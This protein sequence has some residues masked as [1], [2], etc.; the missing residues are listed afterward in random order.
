MD[1]QLL[2]NQQKALTTDAQEIFFG[3]ALGGGK[4]FLLRH[5][6]V[7]Y[8]LYVP[9]ITT[10]LL[11]RTYKDLTKNHVQSQH[12]FAEILQPFIK[13]GK[14]EFNLTDMRIDFHHEN[15]PDSH[16]YLGH[17]Q[18]EKDVYNYQGMEISGLL[19]FDELTH[20]T[21]TIYTYLITRLRSGSNEIDYKEVRKYLPW[22]YD[23]YFPKI[24]SASNP[25]GIGA[26]FARKRWIDP[27]PPYEVWTA[28]ASEGGMKR[29]YIPSRLQD[30]KFLMEQDPFYGDRVLASGTANARK[31]L[32][33]DW[34]INEGGAVADV[35]DEEVHVIPR[36]HIPDNAIIY[37][38]LDWGTFHPSVVLYALKC[39]GETLYTVDGQELNFPNGTLVIFNEIYNWDGE[40]EN[41][42][43]RKPATEV[44]MQMAE[45]ESQVPWRQRIKPGPADRQIFQQR[46]GTH[47]TIDN[48]ISKGYNQ[49]MRNLAEKDSTF[50]WRYDIQRLFEQAD[51]QTG[52]RVT[53]LSLVR[54]FL[55]A[56]LQYHEEG[57]DRRSLFFTENARH[58]I[59]TIPGLPR[60][61]T[62]PEDVQTNHVPDHAYDVVRYLCLAQTGEYQPLHLKGI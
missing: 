33:G 8:G 5:A 25:G 15:G 53:G 1:L 20:F 19:L 40:D 35:W 14:C 12:G 29:I 2:P 21:K 34:S 62:N 46:G 61:E 31:L 38:A 47:D 52:S 55:M 42:G 23:G 13:A 59:A 41:N 43:N 60:S 44:G 11:R 36:I 6:A 26:A 16:I 24:I 10:V 3:G 57:A 30:N 39:N 49:Y 9:G 37:R 50:R 7:I 18:Y 4:S 28:P 51:Q 45:F 48:L 32:D 58:C 54:D 17:A 27:A 56:S 22:V